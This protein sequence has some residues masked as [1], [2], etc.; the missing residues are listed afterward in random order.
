MSNGTP[1]RTV[2]IDDGLWEASQA[3]A[4]ERGENL[5]DVIREALRRYVES[6]NP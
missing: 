6:V 2:R 5:S 3:A 4:S 1:I